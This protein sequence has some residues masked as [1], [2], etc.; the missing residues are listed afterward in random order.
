VTVPG[1]DPPL[2]SIGL[3]VRNGMPYLP[4]ALSAITAQSHTRLEIVICDNGSTDETQARC[5]ELAAT[6]RRVQYIRF[7]QDA[8]ASENFNRALRLS[9]A[10]YFTWAASDD[11]F[12]PS[13]VHD[14]LRAI[15]AKPECAMC[16]SSVGFIDETGEVINIVQEDHRLASPRLATRLR[17]F[18]AR[19]EWYLIY[20]LARRDALLD[21]TLL[22][23]DYGSDVVLMWQL[24]LT[25]PFAVVDDVLVEYRKFRAKTRA[26]VLGGLQAPEQR[27]QLRFAHVR[28][29]WR[30]WVVAGERALSLE[31]RATARRSLARWLV[32]RHWRT[33][34]FGDVLDEASFAFRSRHY[35][36]AAMLSSVLFF[37]QPGRAARGVVRS[38]RRRL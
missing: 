12:A 33:L 28:M 6:D 38:A 10:A 17:A 29:W 3:P 9:T 24:V 35:A 11:R 19:H 22:T 5:E 27:T 30:M 21:T 32:S 16:I 1:P 34:L 13:Y 8:G 7:E 25:H 23:A 4:Q 15:E 18:L 2:V 26:D 14:L 20:G 37:I 36:R 31:D